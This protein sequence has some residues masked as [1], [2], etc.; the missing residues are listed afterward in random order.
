[1]CCVGTGYRIRISAI[2]VALWSTLGCT[3]S[4]GVVRAA[5]LALKVFAGLVVAVLVFLP[6][7]AA[8]TTL[9]AGVRRLFE[10]RRSN[11]DSR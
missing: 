11:R 3:D 4:D 7:M 8:L 5:L 1:M 10:A 9:R 2:A 6:L